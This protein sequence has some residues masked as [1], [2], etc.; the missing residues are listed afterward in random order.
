MITLSR[1]TLFHIGE[2][3]KSAA[4]YLRGSFCVGRHDR[5]KMRICN[6]HADF[7]VD[8]MRVFQDLFTIINLTSFYIQSYNQ[9][10]TK[11]NIEF[12]KFV[13]GVASCQV[14]KKLRSLS[15][16]SFMVCRHV[17]YK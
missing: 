5:S 9:G 13:F 12:T 6:R 8:I 1:N 16:K 10:D 14:I 17:W 7:L 11:N 15:F 2:G 4:A 3:H